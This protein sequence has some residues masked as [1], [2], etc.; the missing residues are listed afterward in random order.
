MKSTR[1]V[2]MRRGQSWMLYY[3]GLQALP[4]VSD[5]T[6]LTLCKQVMAHLTCQRR[7][8]N[9]EKK[10]IFPHTPMY[11][12][13]SAVHWEYAIA[14]TVKWSLNKEQLSWQIAD[15]P[16]DHFYRFDFKSLEKLCIFVL[17]CCLIYTRKPCPGCLQHH[18]FAC[19][20]CNLHST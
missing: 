17:I 8:T 13:Y 2:V 20:E 9:W 14:P 19:H 18:C 12:I 11:I 7:L 10:N 4:V 1:T 5:Q 6:R 15:V 16:A 3:M